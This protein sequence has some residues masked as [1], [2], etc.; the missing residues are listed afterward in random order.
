MNSRK[1][2]VSNEAQGVSSN[3]AKPAFLGLPV[4]IV[5]GICLATLLLFLAVYVYAKLV[6]SKRWNFLDR[7][8]VEPL[9]L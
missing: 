6:V 4:L 3:F 1:L 2:V 8:Y 9:S 5:S 7:K